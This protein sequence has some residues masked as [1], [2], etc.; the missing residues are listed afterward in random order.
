MK[1]EAVYL[2]HILDAIEK[3]ESYTSGGRK[4]FF[5]NTMVHDAVIR[6]LEVIGE[7]LDD[8]LCHLCLAKVF[9]TGEPIVNV[10]ER[11]G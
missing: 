11:G 7:A 5:Q 6:N 8:E 9:W 3:I 4:P 2:K 10:V 1:D